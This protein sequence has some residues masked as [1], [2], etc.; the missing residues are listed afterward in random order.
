METH[1]RCTDS[2]VIFPLKWRV[3]YPDV[4]ICEV[5]DCVHVG[6]FCLFVYVIYFLLVWAWTW[7]TVYSV[8]LCIYLHSWWC[9]WAWVCVWAAVQLCRA[10]ESSRSPACTRIISR[11]QERGSASQFSALPK[12]VKPYLHAAYH[13]LSSLYTNIQMSCKLCIFM[14]SAFTLLRFNTSTEWQNWSF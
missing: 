4:M 9:V 8:Y 7:K 14:H 2:G 1:G 12:A 5:Q 10:V 11:S 13:P 3:F 6:P